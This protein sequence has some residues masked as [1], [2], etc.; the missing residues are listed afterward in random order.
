MNDILITETF[1]LR[2]LGVLTKIN[3]CKGHGFWQK[4]CLYSP[5]RKTA[6]L[7]FEALQ[8]T[9][10]VAAT[11]KLLHALSWQTEHS[12]NGTGPRGR[13]G[14]WQCLS[15]TAVENAHGDRQ[16]DVEWNLTFPTASWYAPRTVQ[17]V[18]ALLGTKHR[19]GSKLSFRLSLKHRPLYFDMLS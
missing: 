1:E 4:N 10:S 16:G 3:Q 18:L 11:W 8:L 13:K 2:K 7:E 6:L 9:A 12:Q 15:K 5:S 19:A 14:T 17:R